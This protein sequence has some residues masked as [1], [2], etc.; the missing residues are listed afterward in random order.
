M[1]TQ[2]D[3]ESLFTQIATSNV[4]WSQQDKEDLTWFVAAFSEGLGT[5][6]A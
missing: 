2:E 3:F 4:A 6:A 5:A 1:Q